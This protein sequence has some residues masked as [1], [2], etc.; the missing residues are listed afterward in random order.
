MK[1]ELGNYY[2][3]LKPFKA[4]RE[5]VVYKIVAVDREKEDLGLRDA[6]H[7]EL[8]IDFQELNEKNFVQVAGYPS[9]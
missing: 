9:K 7:Y 8:I 4:V 2:K 3:A 5:G 1:D 6:N